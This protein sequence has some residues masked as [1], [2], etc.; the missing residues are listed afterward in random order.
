MVKVYAKKP[1]AMT[2]A[3]PYPARESPLKTKTGKRENPS[4]GCYV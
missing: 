1:A 2:V 3:A 4:A